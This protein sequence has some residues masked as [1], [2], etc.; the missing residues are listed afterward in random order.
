MNPFR[1]RTNS[2]KAS[3]L[4]LMMTILE[5]SKKEAKIKVTNKKI[6]T[7]K[8]NLT[9]RKFLNQSS[10]KINK[11]TKTQDH[12]NLQFPRDLTTQINPKIKKLKQNK[13]PIPTVP[14]HLQAPAAV[15]AP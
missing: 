14:L 6:V 11:I 10:L 12:Q 5:S 7:K 1:K 4:N 3:P 15:E 2:P 8:K 9:I 13:S